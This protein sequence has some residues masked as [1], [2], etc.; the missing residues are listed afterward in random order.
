MSRFASLFILLCL[1]ACTLPPNQV[2]VTALID[3]QIRSVED[4]N[5]TEGFETPVADSFEAFRE[6]FFH[7]WNVKSSQLSVFYNSL[8]GRDTAFLSG[9]LTDPEYYGPNKQR[10]SNRFKEELADNLSIED[11]P[12]A[13]T[14]A[15]T[16]K[17]TDIR[18]LPSIEPAFDRYDKAGEGYPFDYF[19]ESAIWANTPVLILH[20]TRD[21]AWAFSLTPYY[22]GWIRAD[23][24][25]K[26]DQDFM[27][28]WE[29]SNLFTIID[30]GTPLISEG[31]E[32]IA[33]G[34]IGML[35]PGSDSDEYW[36]ATRNANGQAVAQKI[37]LN[38]EQI[39][40]F[41]LSFDL[42]NLKALMTQ[43]EGEPYGWGG[44]LGNRDCSATI[45]DLMIPFG[46]WLPRNSTDQAACG[47]KDVDLPEDSTKKLELIRE[48]GVPFRTILYKRGHSMLYVGLDEEDNPLIFHTIW[49]LKPVFQD[50]GLAEQLSTYPLE[51]VHAD[52]ETGDLYGRYV[53][54][55]TIL[56]TVHLGQEIPNVSSTIL[57]D[58]QAMT[59][60]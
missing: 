56:S 55:R 19:Q 35:L 22:K 27:D 31:Q 52:S 39:T 43:I 51:G 10:H 54:G 20:Y 59:I 40:S 24:L 6:E 9:Y 3:A 26:V 38:Q 25:A 28:L 36:A 41:P 1:F 2:D 30:D 4:L 53:I 58:L 50:A 12:N 32:N 34:R 21:R 8:P 60:F 48:E 7:P 33:Q 23:H 45:R 42:P 15:I 46:K 16:V 29:E 47:R 44:Y 57:E 17:N 11:F 37:S 49:G 5:T 14:P 13:F 18:R